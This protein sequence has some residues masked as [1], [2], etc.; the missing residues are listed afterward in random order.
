[1]SRLAGAEPAGDDTAQDRPAETR[2]ARACDVRNTQ[3]ARLIFMYPTVDAIH[4][5]TIAICLKLVI[6]HR[7]H[8]CGP[9]GLLVPVVETPNYRPGLRHLS[10]PCRCRWGRDS[11]NIHQRY[12]VSGH[13]YLRLPKATGRRAPRNQLPM[14]PISFRAFFQHRN[15]RHPKI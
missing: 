15:R 9:V 7:C 5:F 1:V 6:L 11:L 10:A 12:T 2:H 8:H 3:D 13:T 4:A 14:P